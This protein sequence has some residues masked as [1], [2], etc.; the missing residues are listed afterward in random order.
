MNAEA[1]QPAPG[2]GRHAVMREV[3]AT[4]AVAAP[5]AAAN[6]AQMALGFTDTVMV[7]YLGGR[8]L[9]AAGLGAGLYFM[10]V[11]VFQGVLS[12]VSP[13]AARAV[14]AGERRVAGE[15]LA[16]GLALA[17]LLALPIGLGIANV[18]RLLRLMHYEPALAD[19]VGGFLRA[20]VWGVPAFLG[21]A[22]L[23]GFLAAVGRAGAVT[24]VLLACVPTNA[25]LNGILVFGHFG[26]PPLGIVGSGYASALTQW[27]ML[28]GTICYAL[29]A[30]RLGE[31][32]AA[33]RQWANLWRQGR[34]ILHLGLPI[35]GLFALEVGVFTTASVLMGLLGA[36]ALAAH[37][38]VLNCASTTFMVPL[39]I[40]Q[41]AT[42]R[43]AAERGAGRPEAAAR[44]AAVA[45]GLGIGFMAAAALVLWTAPGVI[46][47]IYLDPAAPANREVVGIAL[48]LLAVAALFQVF[49]G[50]Q[51][52]AAGALRGYEDTRTPMVLAALGYWGIG[53]TGA[54]ALAFPLGLG[55]VGLWWGLALG[56][57]AVAAMLTVQLRRRERA[58]RL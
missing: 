2:R 27:A 47:S 23:R 18:D 38:L 34:R 21:F 12:A 10:V 43:V 55:P 37:Q 35:A 17:A 24:V 14:G 28:L 51:V 19:Q 11:V 15:V 33:A 31:Y 20:I 45:L 46:V 9:A 48:R 30:P 4:L 32:R 49:D 57:A 26:M 39:G 6:V 1:V 36:D 41:A 44:A 50:T 29:V 22:A 54:W 25:A 58:V 42:V 52:V 13:L 56:L 8:A 16:A 7:G 53:F 5:L 40:S 3:A